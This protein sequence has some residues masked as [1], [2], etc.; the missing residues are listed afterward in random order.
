MKAGVPRILLVEDDPVSRAFLAAVLMALPARVETASSAAGALACSSEG[1]RHDLWMLDAHLADA[2]GA[3]LLARLRAASPWVPAI[4]HTA[5]RDTAG[6][7]A[8]RAAGFTEV[9]RKPIAAPALRAAVRR[10]LRRPVAVAESSP[11]WDDAVAMAALRND[12]DHVGALRLL[13]LGELPAQR[14][15]VASA[16]AAGDHRS[17]EAV[18]HRLRASCGFV[19]AV[20]LEAAV[21]ALQREPASAAALR[22]FI[23]AADSLAG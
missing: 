7:A 22:E 21:C 13:F 12:G 5:A 2:E 14:D 16:C 19:G 23:R 6:A 17:A 10:A 1:P 15:A 4:A 18:L 9:L 11:Q 8:L 20:R 3:T